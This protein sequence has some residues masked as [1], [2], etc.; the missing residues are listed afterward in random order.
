MTNPY[1]P[2]PR[3]LERSSTDRMVGGVCAGVAQYLNLDPALVRVLTVVL[4]LLTGGVP[5][6]V[7][8]IALFVM[9]EAPR[10]G[11]PPPR[12]PA[13]PPRASAP[14]PWSRTPED[15]VVWGT[16]GAPW[17]QPQPAS[18]PPAPRPRPD[19]PDPG[20]PGPA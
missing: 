9:P 18:P 12:H 6:V 14:G 20:R 3:K 7:Y 4:T 5:L 8:L 2:P 16:E 19:D 17:E 11:G 1:L 15:Q 10:P 13:V